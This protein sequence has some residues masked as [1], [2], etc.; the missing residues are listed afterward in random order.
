[1]MIMIRC[2]LWR[3]SAF[4]LNKLRLFRIDTMYESGE[5]DMD[6][7]PREKPDVPDFWIPVYHIISISSG[8]YLV[9]DI[10]YNILC[11]WI[12][13]ARDISDTS[14]DVSDIS[15]REP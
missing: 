12:K 8:I 10:G 7:Y 15:D 5:Y 14:H 2:D 4:L 13:L 3:R 11:V 1:M 6:T 9:V